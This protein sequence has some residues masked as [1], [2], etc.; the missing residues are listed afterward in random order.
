MGIEIDQR[1]IAK[2]NLF[3]IFGT[4]KRGGV[5]VIHQSDIVNE[6]FLLKKK[7]KKNSKEPGSC[8]KCFTLRWGCLTFLLQIDPT[9]YRQNKHVSI[10]TKKM[11]YIYI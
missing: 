5:V 4:S 1:W 2:N 3:S 11:R 6:F 10:L 7:R 9:I 8:K